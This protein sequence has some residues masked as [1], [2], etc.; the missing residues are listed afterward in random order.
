[1]CIGICTFPLQRPC[2]PTYDGLPFQ[3]TELNPNFFED[4]AGAASKDKGAIL[5]CN[6]GGKIEATE[7]NERGT[8]SR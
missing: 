3:G 6:M 8:Q 1:M 4:I 5:V 7:T 2:L